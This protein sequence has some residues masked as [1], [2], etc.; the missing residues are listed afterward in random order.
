MIEYFNIKLSLVG[1][2]QTVIDID[3]FTALTLK[4]LHWLKKVNLLW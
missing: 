1:L 2:N 3:L 4:R